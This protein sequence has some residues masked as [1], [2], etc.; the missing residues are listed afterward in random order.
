MPSELDARPTMDVTIRHRNGT[1][2][3]AIGELKAVNAA[4]RQRIRDLESQLQSAVD[5]RDF[6]KTNARLEGLSRKA[7]GGAV[8]VLLA[9]LAW[10]GWRPA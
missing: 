3:D 9:L 4:L 5:S 2:R 10:V 8:F 6:W 7:L 1:K